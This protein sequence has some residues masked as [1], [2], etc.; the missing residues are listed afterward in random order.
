MPGAVGT[1]RSFTGAPPAATLVVMAHPRM[2]DDGDRHFQRVRELALALP[3]AQMKVSHGR[4]AFFTT[5]VFAYYGASVNEVR[6]RRDGAVLP[7]GGT[8][9]EEWGG[10][11]QYPRALVITPEEE[12]VSFLEQDPRSFRPAYLGASGWWGIDLTAL[13]P[14]FGAAS[15]DGW[16]EVSEWIETSYRLTAPARLV[17]QLGSRRSGEGS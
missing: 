3:E 13:D 12:D 2:Y 9:S 6:A 16:A 1:T 11:V 8:A 17:R 15:A 7:P 4:P 14:G 5:R 10:Y